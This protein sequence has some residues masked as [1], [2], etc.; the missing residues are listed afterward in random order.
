MSRGSGARWLVPATS[1]VVLLLAACQRSRI[2]VR[3]LPPLPARGGAGASAPAIAAVDVATP[4]SVERRVSIEALDADV[5]AVL[6]ALA[7]Q[8]GVNIVVDPTVRSRV[9]LSLRDV[10]VSAAIEAV[11]RQAG[12][13][14]AGDA[15]FQ[16][17]YGPVVFYQLPVNVDALDVEG[18]MKRF[19]VG[20]E[21]A[22]A[23]VQ[24]REA[25]RR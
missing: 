14:V 10:P 16:S 9:T 11:M 15:S 4:A 19:G 23:I 7:Q 2:D 6:L 3:P 8:G 5:R 25:Q 20:R 17:P 24:G 21:I 22:E 18:I 1:T 13:Q 12:L